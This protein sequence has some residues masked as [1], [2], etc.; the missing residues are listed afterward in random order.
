M[1]SNLSKIL[2]DNSLVLKKG[3][4]VIYATTRRGLRPL[5]DCITIEKSKFDSRECVLFDK[6]IGL[7]AARLVVYC[8]FI[9]SV[10]ALLASKKAVE[11]LNDS[12]VSIQ[13]ETVVDRILN[14]D[15]SASCP[16]EQKA[17]KFSDNEAFYAELRK[18]FA[19]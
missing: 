5:F 3:D 18:T 17:S 10:N 9:A 14:M 2:Q 11:L 7:A 6:V 1:V 16:M 19:S 12:G 4:K 8:G 13:A 15:K